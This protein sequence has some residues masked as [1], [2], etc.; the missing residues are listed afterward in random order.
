M[1]E[2]PPIWVNQR[3]IDARQLKLLSILHFVGAGL[4]IV[5]IFL[6]LGHYAFMHMVFTNPK[7]METQRQGPPPEQILA[8]LKVFYLACGAFFLASGILNL[9]SGLFLRARKYRTF[10][11]VVAAL[12][13]L[14]I[15]M[16][17]ILGISTILI[18]N[19]ASVRETY[20]AQS[21]NPLF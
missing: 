15:P 17:T 8:I 6:V 2:L 4:A 9:I 16:G 3:D 1:S 20:N 21:Q 5:G 11:I 12:N 14:H 18:L 13:C 10:S 7:F 19:R